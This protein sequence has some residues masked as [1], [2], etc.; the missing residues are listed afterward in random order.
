[1]ELAKP[2][3]DQLHLYFFSKGK[4]EFLGRLGWLMLSVF[5]EPGW[6]DQAQHIGFIFYSARH[7]YSANPLSGES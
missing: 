6:S 2:C 1:M 5:H 4:N 3:M 7:A